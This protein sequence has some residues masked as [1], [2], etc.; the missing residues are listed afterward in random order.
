MNQYDDIPTSVLTKAAGMTSGLGAAPRIYSDPNFID[1][2][3][4]ATS[5]PLP[6]GP[7]NFPV[8][9][10]PNV[11]PTTPLQALQQLNQK[12][13]R[14]IDETVRQNIA[15]RPVI[16]A[17]DVTNAGQTLN[18][19]AV[20]IMDRVTL[21]ND[22][23]DPV[24]LAFDM[25][26]QAVNAFTSDLSFPLKADSTL[27]LTHSLFTKIGVKTASG[28]TATVNAIAWQSVAGNQAAAIS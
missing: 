4:P 19:Q 15:S 10:P 1:R 9:Q 20:G 2:V 17:K 5:M 25:N 28:K 11:L 26:G 3:R 18:W 24:W 23:P 21:K 27:N 6:P 12:M 8:A 14:L 22:G 16:R 7:A 13:D